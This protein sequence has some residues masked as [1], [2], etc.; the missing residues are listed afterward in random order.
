M[1]LVFT[2]VFLIFVFKFELVRRQFIAALKLLL[3]A[4]QILKVSIETVLGI[5]LTKILIRLSHFR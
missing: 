3:V 5:Q 1:L 2:N 4:I